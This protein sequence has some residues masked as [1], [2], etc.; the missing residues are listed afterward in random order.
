MLIHRLDGADASPLYRIQGPRSA[1]SA[2]SHDSAMGHARRL[3]A[4][5][6]DIYRRDHP[7]ALPELVEQ[8]RRTR[9]VS[10]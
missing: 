9:V 6:C 7:D 10:S 3:G 1:Y 5:A 8:R 4:N 2:I